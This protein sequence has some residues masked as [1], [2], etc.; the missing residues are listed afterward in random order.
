MATADHLYTDQCITLPVDFAKMIRFLTCKFLW[1]KKTEKI[2]RKTLY[3]NTDQEGIELINA[4]NKCK[5]L[6]LQHAK[7]FLTTKAR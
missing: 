6:K 5:A 3:N 7:S 4:E 1:D 2:G